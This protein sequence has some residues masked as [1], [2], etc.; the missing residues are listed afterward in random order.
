MT[1]DVFGDNPADFVLYE[2]DGISNAFK[3][4]MQSEIRL[5]WA[6]GEGTV[7]RNGKYSGLPRYHIM[8]WEQINGEISSAK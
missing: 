6:H 8:K 2:D 4:K 1:V 5:H 3:D 7:Q